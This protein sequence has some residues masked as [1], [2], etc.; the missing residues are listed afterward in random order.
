MAN[1]TQDVTLNA[2]ELLAQHVTLNVRL[3]GLKFA[4]FRIKCAISLIWLAAL[5]AGVGI[6]VDLKGDGTG[7]P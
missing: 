3:R 5:V 6:Q 1:T 4:T 7:E 2:G